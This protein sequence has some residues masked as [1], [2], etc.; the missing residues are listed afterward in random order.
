MSRV[1][2]ASRFFMPT[3]KQ[4][5][6]EAVAASHQLL[7]RAGFIRQLGAGLYSY[8]PLGRRSL[9]RIERILR[10]EMHAVGAEEVL[11]P[12]LHPAELWRESGRWDAIDDAMFRLQ[13][14]RGGEYCLAMTHEEV[15]AAIARADLHSY[16]QL[17]QRWFQIGPKFRDEPRPRA[18]LLR[19]REFLMKDAYSFDLDAA[20]LD[21][22]FAAMRSAYTRI[23]ARCGLEVWPAE[24]FPG[25][26]G[27]RESIEFV[28]RTDVGEDVVLHCGA[29][30]YTANTEVARSR[31]T[32]IN[33]AP[34]ELDT[35]ESFETPGVVTIEALASPPYSVAATQQLKTLIYVADGQTVVAVVRGDDSLNEAKLQAATGA[36]ALRP[37]QVEEI[38]ALMGAHPGSLG[39][40][41]FTGAPVL[42]D[43]TLADR[44]NMVTGANRDGY[45]LRGVH[46]ARDILS[47][48]GARAAD[49]RAVQAG[50]GCP[51]CDAR[52]GVLESFSALEVGHIFK[53]G[54]RYSARLGAT[55][56]DASGAERPLV[57]G[58]YG[59]GL[60]RLMA[61]VVEA[62]HDDDG[63][64]WPASIAPF[65]ATVLVLGAEPELAALAEAAAAVLEQ[66]GLDVLLDDRDERAGVKFK[67][68]DLIGIPVR[69]GVG[70]RAPGSG[71]IEAKLRNGPDV[72]A[73]PLAELAEWVASR[74]LPQDQAQSSSNS[75]S[76][77]A[78]P[79]TDSTDGKS[80]AAAKR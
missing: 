79:L 67:D 20:G 13:D 32:R 68:A 28:V 6:V 51:N 31:P 40:V 2:R 38:V 17:P 21:A 75:A 10:E 23:F 73:V 43:E 41:A 65:D 78:S 59:I 12:A 15:V 26:M 48:S 5:P 54:T 25:A 8:L 1:V 7:V 47:G 70:R 57:M 33:D 71:A 56:L 80:N 69:I 53:Q 77:G 49:L 14:R 11:A 46:V 16:R 19:V 52:D 3:M 74:P 30:G 63:I 35:P 62:H 60:G 9:A 55:V 50:E 42:L 58:A 4:A 72:D 24:A 45:H 27:G 39:S 61:A 36:S 22:S 66:A 64:I 37:A 29:C 18:G 34:S 76:T 44:T